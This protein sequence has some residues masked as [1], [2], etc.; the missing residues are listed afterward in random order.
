MK[1]NIS[2][3]ASALS[4]LWRS[5]RP[6]QKRK[7]GIAIVLMV[8]ASLAEVISIG[9]VIPFIMVLIDPE[10]LEANVIGKL[11]LSILSDSLRE[12]LISVLSSIFAAAAIL[13]TIIRISLLWI[14]NRAIYSAGSDISSDIFKRTLYQKYE[15][16]IGRSS[17]EMINALT[18]EVAVVINYA[19]SPL[20]TLTSSI[21][22]LIGFLLAMMAYSITASMVL[23]AIFGVV[24][25]AIIRV[26]RQ[27]LLANSAIIR[28]E[29]ERLVAS[30]AEAI[31]GIRD[32]IITGSQNIYIASHD[33]VDRCL[34]QT[35]SNNQFI[36]QSPRFIVEGISLVAIA[37]VALFIGDKK[38]VVS[39]SLPLIGALALAAQRVLPILQQSYAAWAS[40]R[41]STE[42]LE[43]VRS[44]L[45]QPISHD[46]E[47]SSSPIRLKH[48]IS[49]REISF[50]YNERKDYVLKNVSFEI[51]RGDIVGIIGTTGSGKSTLVDILMGLLDPTSGSI[52]ID[53]LEV[54]GPNRQQWQKQISHV[55][56][57]IYLS[58]AT[59]AENIAFG[60]PPNKID[61]ERVS[62]VASLAMIS[63]M[64][65]H[66]PDRYLTR[67]GEN[68]VR[69][70]GGERQ[71]IGI[72]RGLYRN[73]DV[74][75]LDEATSA[76]DE[77]TESLVIKSIQDN[78]DDATIIMVAH[79]LS[80][81][82]KCNR[83]FKVSGG[84]VYEMP[85][86]SQATRDD[87]DSVGAHK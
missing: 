8:F 27:R 21:I 41:G 48:L 38:A 28:E 73:T 70:S 74:L 54:F 12:N 80:T 34:R 81:L 72:A 3:Y 7:I 47:S 9:A 26:S 82:K 79:R 45:L 11:L 29:S 43:H 17:S 58:D 50:R 31:G 30:T 61:Y 42:Q 10:R 52:Y 25:F 63:N 78:K 44:L 51:R 76:L 60:I 15:V 56:Q 37:V 18:T 32:I 53:E 83:I 64:I 1:S 16:H 84:H 39:E 75:V 71:R 66:L 59:I 67:V 2:S 5:I 36:N 23:I 24:Y 62:K 14:S 4:Q 22:I 68:G 6:A 49:F 55:P 35:Q 33:R 87:A 19:L 65:E 40:I 69:F 85:L 77:V 20:M 13:A 86:E 46:T 57:R